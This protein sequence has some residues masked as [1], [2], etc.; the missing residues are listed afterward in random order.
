MLSSPSSMYI[1]F[2]IFSFF[3]YFLDL[4]VLFFSHTHRSRT[5]SS[6]FTKNSLKVTY[7]TDQPRKDEITHQSENTSNRLSGVKEI[8]LNS[9]NGLLYLYKY[10]FHLFKKI[11]FFKH[12]FPS[13]SLYKTVKESKSSSFLKKEIFNFE[14]EFR[15]FWNSQLFCCNRFVIFL[16]VFFTYLF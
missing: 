4:F 1:S 15:V 7:I 5:K 2:E 14:K 11:L 9:Y 10:F 6:L 13:L 8:E 3:W 16:Y 12:P